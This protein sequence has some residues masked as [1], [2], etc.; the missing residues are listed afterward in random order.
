MFYTAIVR[1]TLSI[2]GIS[3]ILTIKTNKTRLLT[4]LS[5]IDVNSIQQK[6]EFTDLASASVQ[7]DFQPP[8]YNDSLMQDEFLNSAAME[9]P[10]DFSWVICSPSLLS[11]SKLKLTCNLGCFRSN[12]VPTN[13]ISDWAG[14]SFYRAGCITILLS[15]QHFES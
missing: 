15:V 3:A 11:P 8:I 4:P 7:P 2:L 13:A 9:L 12:H 14:L 10:T 1:L 6:L 5:N